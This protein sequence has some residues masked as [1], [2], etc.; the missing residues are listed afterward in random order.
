MIREYLHFGSFHKEL[1]RTIAD[2]LEESGGEIT[3]EELKTVV[4]KRKGY[5]LQETIMTYE[6]AQQKTLISLFRYRDGIVYQN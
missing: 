1:R 5:T 4:K 2:I 6:Q 3:L